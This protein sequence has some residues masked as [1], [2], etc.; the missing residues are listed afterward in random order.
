MKSVRLSLAM[1]T[2]MAVGMTLAG[3]APKDIAHSRCESHPLTTADEWTCTVTGDV[4]ASVNSIEYDT[5]SRNHVAK[6]IVA[7]QVEKGTLRLSYYDLT[8]QKQLLVT[9]SEPASFTM[10]TPMHRERRSFTIMYEPV[11]G[12]VHGLKGTVN[13]STP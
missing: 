3:C 11:N 7:I 9:P 2:A 12:P 6:V 13:Y 4:V 1:V 5:E 10:Q 8:G